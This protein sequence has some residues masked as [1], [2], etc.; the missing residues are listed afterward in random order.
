MGGVWSNRTWL[1][2]GGVP[3]PLQNL[4]EIQKASPFLCTHDHSCTCIIHSFIYLFIYFLLPTATTTQGLTATDMC[5]FIYS[6][7]DF[8]FYIHQGFPVFLSG[9]TFVLLWFLFRIPFLLTTDSVYY[10]KY[11]SLLLFLP[12]FLVLL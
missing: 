8:F 2:C 4:V 5:C 12:D 10:C 6:A 1:W 7:L 9:L 3:A 11:I